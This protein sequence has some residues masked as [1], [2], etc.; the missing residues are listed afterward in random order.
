[1][2]PNSPWLTV[3]HLNGSMLTVC[4]LRALGCVFSHICLSADGYFERFAFIGLVA[5]YLCNKFS[6]SFAS[7]SHNTLAMLLG[8][9][10]VFNTNL[11]IS[12]YDDGR[13][14]IGKFIQALLLSSLSRVKVDS[15]IMKLQHA[16]TFMFRVNAIVPP[17]NLVQRKFRI[18]VA[19]WVEHF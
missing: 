19:R 7:S 5:A 15:L 10:L 9:L 4:A 6:L 11:A 14:A 18:E 13:S 2:Q 16:R 3:L 1:M 12:R 17:V 8:F